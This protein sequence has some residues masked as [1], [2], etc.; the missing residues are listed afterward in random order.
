MSKILIC[1]DDSSIRSAI[2]INLRREGYSVLEATTGETALE[3]LK[4]NEDVDIAILDLNLPDIDGINVCK[5]IRENNSKIGIIMLTARVQEEDKIKGLKMGADDYMTKPFS[6]SELIARVSA[7]NRRVSKVKNNMIEEVL[8]CGELTLNISTRE[9]FKN[10]TLIDLTRTEFLLLRMFFENKGLTLDRDKLL[11]H[12]WGENFFG[13]LKIVD[14]NIRRLRQ[15]LEE[16]P[17][18]P[19]LIETVWGKGYR[20]AREEI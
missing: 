14:V 8:T 5:E 18:K 3:L 7:L 2:R 19:K 13:D 11:N 10:S 4:A 17:S 15:K 20:W 16:D 12:I 1:E 6:P 9:C